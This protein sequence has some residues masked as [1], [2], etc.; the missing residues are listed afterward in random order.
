MNSKEMMISINNRINTNIDLYQFFP[1][2]LL[3]NEIYDK[4]YATLMIINPDK[5]KFMSI[6]I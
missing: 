3:T 5:I 1:S 4:W 2:T 6:E